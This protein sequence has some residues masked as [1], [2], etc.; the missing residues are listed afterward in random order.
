MRTSLRS[1]DNQKT[2]VG[3]LTELYFTATLTAILQYMMLQKEPYFMINS[4]TKHQ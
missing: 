1:K 4:V 3:F 2:N